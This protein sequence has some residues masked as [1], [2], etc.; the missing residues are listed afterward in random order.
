MH[1]RWLARLRYNH[2]KLHQLISLREKENADYREKLKTLEEQNLSKND[3]SNE[4]ARFKAKIKINSTEKKQLTKLL[5]P[6]ILAQ[7]KKEALIQLVDL[8][9]DSSSHF[10]LKNEIKFGLLDLIEDQ[11]IAVKDI[12]IPHFNPTQ[13]YLDLVEW[14]NPQQ[15]KIAFERLTTITAK[16]IEDPT[17]KIVNKLDVASINLL[18][19]KKNVLFDL[20]NT[21]NDLAWEKLNDYAFQFP[22]LFTA[23]TLHGQSMLEK[24]S[25]RP[26]LSANKF[27]TLLMTLLENTGADLFHYLNAAMMDDIEVSNFHLLCKR[28]AVFPN[29]KKHLTDL[30]QAWLHSAYQKTEENTVKVLIFLEFEVNL[31]ALDNMGKKNIDLIIEHHPKLLYYL[32]KNLLQFP[33]I[34]NDI[35]VL[36]NLMI[37]S[38]RNSLD[39][40][41][42]FAQRRMVISNDPY[43]EWCTLQIQL[44]ESP[45][46]YE[47]IYNSLLCCLRIIITQ[48]KDYLESSHYLET[49]STNT[50]LDAQLRDFAIVIQAIIQGDDSKLLAT[51][52]H[53]GPS[54][55]KM[56]KDISSQAETYHMTFQPAIQNLL[57]NFAISKLVSFGM[58][59][60]PVAANHDVTAF[61]YEPS[62]PSGDDLYE[63]NFS[64]NKI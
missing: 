20:E 55:T 6:E 8:L 28:H 64:I 5:D 58:F 48:P 54:A 46:N 36:E 57:A 49:S 21:I 14:G 41:R 25:H 43:R 56:A 59:S 12:P 32:A 45:Q 50:K 22:A 37:I 40:R 3:L 1:N 61:C 24:L 26:N 63:N 2:F 7:E 60:P 47:L 38:T 23:V 9:S 62:A 53:L 52:L 29:F 4:K 44:K 17:I 15:R 35:V 27:T 42:I 19:T 39:E 31:L 16:H 10:Q 34:A 33:V 18:L 51:L 13:L 30:L 11:V